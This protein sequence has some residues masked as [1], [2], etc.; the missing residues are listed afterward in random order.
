MRNRVLV[1][2]SLISVF[3]ASACAMT[4]APQAVAPRTRAMTYDSTADDGSANTI[5]FVSKGAYITHIQD[6]NAFA[7]G[8]WIRALP[9]TALWPENDHPPAVFTARVVERTKTA[10]RLEILAYA[11]G[12]RPSYRLSALAYT[13]DARMPDAQARASSLPTYAITKKLL[14]SQ[15]TTASQAI[16]PQPGLNNIRGNELYGAFD[17][18]NVEGRL[19][20]MLHAVMRVTS[21]NSEQAALTPWLGQVPDASAFV[22]LD[23]WTP[24]GYQVQIR[25]TKR[26]ESLRP[27]I[28]KWLQGTLAEP[29]I[30]MMPDND[31]NSEQALGGVQKDALLLYVD[32]RDQDYV[33]E[34]Q[35]LR[36]GLNLWSFAHLQKNADMAALDVVIRALCMAGDHVSAI[37]LLEQA[38][39]QS[40]ADVSLFASLAPSL[41]SRYHAIQRDDWALEIA[42]QA[43][44]YLAKTQDHLLRTRLHLAIAAIA[45][46]I[47]RVDEFKDAYVALASQRSG[48]P[49]LDDTMYFHVLALASLSV[50]EYA[51]S[52]QAAWHRLETAHKQTPLDAQLRCFA[53]YPQKE[54]AC[55]PDT[56]QLTPFDRV[57][58]KLV[59]GIRR[60]VND[61]SEWMQQLADVD[62]VGAPFLAQL[63]WL[64]LSRQAHDPETAEVLKMNA[65]Q[66]AHRSQNH[67][68]ETAMMDE[69]RRSRAMRGYFP[70]NNDFESTLKRWQSL[71]AR[72]HL[73]AFCYDY[74]MQGNP[75][76]DERRHLLMLAMELYLSIGDATNAQTCQN[77][78]K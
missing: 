73:A 40:E 74:A 33:V 30:K 28:V 53:L 64:H 1:L 2:L 11:D 67:A 60:P 51:D 47:G 72:A 26:A 29:Y 62:D 16:V 3:T 75:A 35:M 25:L 55:V 65:A 61:P 19:G 76:P 78:L 5:A 71:D 20:S 50:P 56:E 24:P 27:H 7:Y 59:P 4:H 17:L 43:Q 70:K 9:D 36:I 10:A 18:E 22:L 37:W 48:S 68:A 58:Y 57:F 39:R 45:A 32:R 12:M 6:K 23:A 52:A 63:V 34:D 38:L 8:T 54:D 41:A 69:V 77:A 44:A 14:F 46:E 13:D 21:W 15:H 49:G 42:L 31:A 66:Y